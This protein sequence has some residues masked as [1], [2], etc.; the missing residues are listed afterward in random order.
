MPAFGELSSEPSSVPSCRCFRKY[1][2]Y[3][4]S[5]QSA[6]FKT[7]GYDN[8]VY[9]LGELKGLLSYG[10]ASGAGSFLC[11]CNFLNLIIVCFIPVV[12]VSHLLSSEM[13]DVL[14][15][16]VTALTEEQGLYFVYLQLMRKDI[17]NRVTC[18]GASN[19]V[20]QRGF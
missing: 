6:N 20:M 10:K 16:P 17:R 1:Y 5:I 4:H 9:E 12:Y 11:A 7:L 19:E 15:L 14:V 13:P 8:K 2:G 18:R 3:L